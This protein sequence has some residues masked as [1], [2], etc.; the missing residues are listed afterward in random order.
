[1]LK[2]TRVRALIAGG[3]SVA[4]AMSA[5]AT[6]L[7]QLSLNAMVDEADAVVVATAES[8]RVERTSEGVYTIT[9]FR[10]G[11]AVVGQ[12]S[13]S[14]DVRSEGGSYTSGKF[15]VGE[16]VAGAPIFPIGSEQLLF[17]DADAANSYAVVGFN[18]GASAVY[19][20]PRGKSVRLTGGKKDETLEE[21]KDRIRAA[22]ARNK[23]GD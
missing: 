6:T 15:K 21:A 5:S 8:S 3:L 17:L 9:T 2:K 10:A 23:S 12:M 11:D 14:F 1:M 22:K 18:Q 20:A 19:S 13:G 7:I 4:F 16:S